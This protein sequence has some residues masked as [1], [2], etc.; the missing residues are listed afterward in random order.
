MTVE[1]YWNEVVSRFSK[2]DIQ[3]T[4]HT[5]P[6]ARLKGD[7]CEDCPVDEEIHR[8]GEPKE[9]AKQID[10]LMRYEVTYQSCLVTNCCEVID[11][12]HKRFYK[13]ANV[14]M[15]VDVPW[16]DYKTGEWIVMSDGI[17]DRDCHLS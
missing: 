6:V 13:K 9:V 4:V 7:S 15:E 11:M 17:S 14:N 16:E 5:G 1:E 10:G 8:Y 12:H 2:V 3:I